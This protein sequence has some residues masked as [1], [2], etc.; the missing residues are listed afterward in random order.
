LGQGYLDRLQIEEDDVDGAKNIPTYN[1]VMQRH[2]QERIPHWRSL[3]SLEDKDRLQSGYDDL[4]QALQLVLKLKQL[5][6]DYQWDEMRNILRDPI[7][8]YKLEEA[9]SIL[10]LSQGFMD[11]EGKVAIGFDWGR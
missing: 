6:S 8:T 2:F 10:Q 4:V 11:V 9:C 3:S 5:A 1:E 7:L